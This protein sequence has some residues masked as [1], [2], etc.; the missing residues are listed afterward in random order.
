MTNVVANTILKLLPGRSRGPVA[1]TELDNRVGRH[2]GATWL[3]ART[4]AVCLALCATALNAADAAPIT[5]PEKQM[6]EAA[7]RA[8]LRDPASAIFKHSADVAKGGV[9]CGL[10]NSKN[11]YGGYGGPKPF[12]V[13]ITKGMDQASFS[14]LSPADQEQLAMLREPKAL[15]VAIGSDDTRAEA[16][17]TQCAQNGFDL[18]P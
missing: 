3:V 7:I 16:T 4:S 1:E 18:R 17:M 11:G 6:V 13:M 8:R 14:Q 5:N 2:S 15:V 9:Y 10:V 12:I